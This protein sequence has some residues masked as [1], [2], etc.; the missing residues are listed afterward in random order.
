MGDH[1]GLLEISVLFQGLDV[2][3]IIN[4]LAYHFLDG[5]QNTKKNYFFF[6]FFKVWDYSYRFATQN[7]QQHHV[8][9]KLVN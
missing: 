1:Q 2:G 5:E 3:F 4:L 8:N 6:F 7:H 9:E